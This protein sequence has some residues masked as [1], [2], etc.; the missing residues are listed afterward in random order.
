MFR[1]TLSRDVFADLDRLQRELQQ[2]FELSPSIRGRGRGF[3]ALNVGSTPTTLEVQAFVPGV[4]PASLEVTVERGA[5]TLTGQ[6]VGV[7]PPARATVH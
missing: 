6:R 4:D 3:P 7:A 5:L 2:A 1:T